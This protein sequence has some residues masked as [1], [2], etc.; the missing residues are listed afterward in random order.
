MLHQLK[1][2][3]HCTAVPISTEEVILRPFGKLQLVE[4]PD[5]IE[6]GPDNTEKCYRPEVMDLERVMLGLGLDERG[7]PKGGGAEV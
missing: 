3:S 5:A 7:H 2:P 4:N 1:V 6:E